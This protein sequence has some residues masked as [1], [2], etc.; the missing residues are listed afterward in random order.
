MRWW[1][2]FV[3]RAQEQDG[4]TIIEVL[5][6]VLVL[7]VG[8]A[9]AFQLLIVTSHQTTTSRLRQAETSLARELTDDSRS[10]PYTQLNSSGSAT[11]LQPNVANSTVT[12]TSPS[13]S[14]LSVQRSTTPSS[15]A[16]YAFTATIT[17][18]S[19]DDPSDGYGDHSSSPSSGGSW[20]PDALSGTQDPTPDDYKRVSVTITP[21]GKTTPAVQQAVLVYNRVTHGPAVTCLSTSATTCPGA[22]QTLTTG[23][24]LKFYV[25]TSTPAAAIQWLVNGSPPGSSQLPSGSDDPYTP[26]GTN[27]STFTWNFPPTP[28]GSTYST[29]DGTY[30]ISAVAFDDNGNSGTRSSLQVT[31][32]LHAGAP[33]TSVT[34]GWNKQINGV[35]VQWVPS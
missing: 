14:T 22:N 12:G 1:S 24:S 27:N 3:T 28:S 31:L 19:L 8:L 33:P 5:T 20:C 11:A 34:A 29:I 2:T 15:G 30:T 13:G 21:S 18:C 10:L 16:S 35:D 26:G 25:T 4:F 32:N 6:A 23:T 17:A 7:G 9:A